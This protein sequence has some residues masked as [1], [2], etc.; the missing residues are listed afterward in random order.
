MVKY[1]SKECQKLSWYEHHK[2]ECPILVR[3]KREDIEQRNFT[4]RRGAIKILLNRKRG[5]IV[6]DIWT[7][8]LALESHV[9]KVLA[10]QGRGPRLVKD[11][12]AL[13]KLTDSPESVAT[14]QRLLCVVEAN[15]FAVELFGTPVAQ[16]FDPLPSLMN[17][18]CN[19]NA[20]IRFDISKH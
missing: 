16:A 13:R 10:H 6:D 8:V 5:V 7:E 18:D 20:H 2:Y 1:C 14:I 9:E 4:D 17:H 12:I 15:K 19:P 11:S 3:N